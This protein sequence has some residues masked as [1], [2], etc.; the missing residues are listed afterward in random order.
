VDEGESKASREYWGGPLAT[1]WLVISCAM[2][3]LSVPR[4]SR[5]NFEQFKRDLDPLVLYFHFLAI[6]IGAFNNKVLQVFIVYWNSLESLQPGF[7][8]QFFWYNNNNR[9]GS[10]WDFSLGVPRQK[11]IRI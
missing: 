5:R 7:L 3:T 9:H 11:A 1:V 4:L 10:Q 8:I 6:R 2:P